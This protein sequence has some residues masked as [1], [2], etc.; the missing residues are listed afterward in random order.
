MTA[1]FKE[2]AKKAGLLNRRFMFGQ[3]YEDE[4]TDEQKKFAELM[5]AE[6]QT[7]LRDNSGADT[8]TLSYRVEDHF[9]DKK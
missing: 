2:L 7:I 5:V 6:F 9:K 8:G 3:Y 4:L 1:R